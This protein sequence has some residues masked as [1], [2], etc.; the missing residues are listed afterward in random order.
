MQPIVYLFFPGGQCRAAFDAYGK[1]FGATPQVMAFSSIPPEA[2]GPPPDVPGDM[3]MHAELRIGTGTIYGS[4]APGETEVMAGCNVTLSL[5]DANETRRV[6][7]AL[8]QDGEVRQPL[9]PT[10]FAPLYSAFTDRFGIRW[11]VMQDGAPG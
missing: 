6:F 5:P 8:S 10:F 3:V 9:E 2:G 11:M 4:D 7:E 1:V